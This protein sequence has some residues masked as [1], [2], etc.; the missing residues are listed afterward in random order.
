MFWKPGLADL[1]D[2]VGEIGD[3]IVIAELL[4]LD[5]EQKSASF[6][7]FEGRGDGL[8][9]GNVPVLLTCIGEAVAADFAGEQRC[10]VGGV[11]DE[12]VHVPCVHDC[13]NTSGGR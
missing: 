13:A 3:V 2:V 8:L 5:A 10:A 9:D 12:E 11:R 1:C 4:S 7:V 6:K